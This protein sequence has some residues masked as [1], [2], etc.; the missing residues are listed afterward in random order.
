MALLAIAMQTVESTL[1]SSVHCVELRSRRLGSFMTRIFKFAITACL[2]AD[3][4][5]FRTNVMS[6]TG[7]FVRK[8][9]LTTHK[10]IHTGEKPYECDVCDRRFTHAKTRNSHKKTQHL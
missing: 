6:V 7:V 5:A 10:R 2:F 4:G 1:R 3:A 8:E 9:H